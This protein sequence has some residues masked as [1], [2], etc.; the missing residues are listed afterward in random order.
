MNIV[1]TGSLGHIGKPLTQQLVSAGHSL[2][3]ISSHADRQPD[4]NA[5]G[6]T[7]AI[8]S[9]EDVDFLAT[10]FT[11]ADAV[12]C[13]I[14]PSYKEPDQI[15]YYSRIGGHYVQAIQQAGVKRV[16]ELSSYGAHLATGTGFIVGSHQN[17]QRMDAALP[18]VAI[19][20]LRPTY[21]YYNLNNFI[22]MI[23]AAGFMGANYGGDDKLAMVSPNDIA[24]AVANEIVTPAQGRNIV[25]LTSDDRTCNE[26]ARVLG[27]A[28]GK[29]DLIW[30]TIS[31]DQMQSGLEASGMP[32]NAAAA[33]VELGGAIHSGMLRE[34]YDRHQPVVG[35]VKLEAFAQEF[36]ARYNR[37]NQQSAH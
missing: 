14:P 30:Q 4:I 3:V 9:V 24:A 21:F 20:H 11:G 19:T 37:E 34:D 29:P 31:S 32:P 10:T 16:V 22:G 8:G 27:N 33:L 35:S 12:Y 5:L 7:A 36:A 18:E 15:A 2:T 13:M 23:K 6:A 28:I 25:Y 1:L 17:E 26:V